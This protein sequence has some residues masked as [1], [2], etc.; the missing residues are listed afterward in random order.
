MF[1]VIVCRV[2]GL[3]NLIVFVFFGFGL[4]FVSC[5]CSLHV[6]AIETNLTTSSCEG[7]SVQCFSCASAIFSTE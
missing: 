4:D 7:S 3:G 1:C 6:S 5:W 2:R